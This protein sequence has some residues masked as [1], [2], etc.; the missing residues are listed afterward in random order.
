[1][2][3]HLP[4]RVNQSFRLTSC[5]MLEAKESMS[6]AL[7]RTLVILWLRTKAQILLPYYLFSALQSCAYGN[8]DAK[9]GGNPR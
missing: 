1:M 2:I 7:V 5:R 3:G 8:H 4:T 9:L 6:L